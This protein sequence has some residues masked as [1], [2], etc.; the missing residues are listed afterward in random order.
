MYDFSYKVPRCTYKRDSLR[1]TMKKKNFK[2]RQ[3]S[4]LFAYMYIYMCTDSFKSFF[5]KLVIS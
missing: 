1:R 2:Q 4:N 3:L 5:F